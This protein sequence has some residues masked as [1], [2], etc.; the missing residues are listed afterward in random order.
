MKRWNHLSIIVHTWSNGA[1]HNGANETSLG[2]DRSI[3]FRSGVH[4]ALLIGCTSEGPYAVKLSVGLRRAT[5]D[6]NEQRL[7]L[8]SAGVGGKY[9][10]LH[11]LSFTGG[12]VQAPFKP[13]SR[14]GV[15]VCIVSEKQNTN[16]VRQGNGEHGF[17]THNQHADIPFTVSK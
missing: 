1:S 4:Q 13:L 6:Q 8:D 14:S 7:L 16:S 2:C 3:L 17:S 12:Y 15:G 10:S 9:R 11:A 5:A